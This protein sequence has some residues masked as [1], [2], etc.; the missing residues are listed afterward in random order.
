MTWHTERILV[1]SSHTV[2]QVATG[3]KVQ[4][5]VAIEVDRQYVTNITSHIYELSHVFNATE[6]FVSFMTAST[7]YR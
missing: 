3:R 7:Y 1:L 4:R 6:I 2:L 5:G